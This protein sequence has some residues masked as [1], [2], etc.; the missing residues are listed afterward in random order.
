M[1]PKDYDKDLDEVKTGNGYQN[2]LIATTNDRLKKTVLQLRYLGDSISTD[3]GSLE[4]SID[5]LERTIFKLDQKNEKLQRIFLWV[6]FIGVLI[7]L[8]QIIQ[9]VDIFKRGLGK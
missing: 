2:D 6:T 5:S 7:S 9:V 1:L 3:L 4:D 8:S